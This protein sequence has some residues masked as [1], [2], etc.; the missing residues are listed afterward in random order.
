MGGSER[1]PN[2]KSD[3]RD[4]K[5]AG[6]I[7]PRSSGVPSVGG[8]LVYFIANL[9]E[10]QSAG[11]RAKPDGIRQVAGFGKQPL[12]IKLAHV[13]FDVRPVLG[14]EEIFLQ[15]MYKHGG[16]AAE[17]ESRA[18]TREGKPSRGAGGR[19]AGSLSR[20][21]QVMLSLVAIDADAT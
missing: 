21:S 9:G 20:G 16:V 12:I 3:I 6:R 17:R 2:P 14:N 4:F 11:D 13:M 10:R 18:M 15:R 19:A 1:S 5:G 8:K 7:R